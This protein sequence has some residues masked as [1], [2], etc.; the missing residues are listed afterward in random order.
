MRKDGHV[1]PTPP[2]LASVDPA[3]CLTPSRLAFSLDSAFDFAGN[4]IEGK[5]CACSSTRL[6]CP[7]SCRNRK[8]L[9]SRRCE[10]GTD[11][12]HSYRLPTNGGSHGWTLSCWRLFSTVESV[13]LN[14]E[15]LA[16]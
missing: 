14:Q 12:P 7:C 15:V 13:W 1:A 9:R 6:N 16:T 5:L 8:S 2:L 10:D 11:R 4:W 3:D